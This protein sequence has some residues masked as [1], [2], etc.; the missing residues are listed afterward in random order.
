L[1]SDAALKNADA[2]ISYWIQVMKKVYI[3]ETAME[4]A[5]NHRVLNLGADYSGDKFL[6]DKIIDIA[7]RFRLSVSYG[8]TRADSC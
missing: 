5:A 7:Q 3:P 8:D 6:I 4:N 1:V 2:E